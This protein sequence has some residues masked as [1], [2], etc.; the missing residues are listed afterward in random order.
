[1]LAASPGQSNSE[2]AFE[3]KKFGTFTYWL[4]DALVATS[5]LADINQGEIFKQVEK[6]TKKE[7]SQQSPFFQGDRHKKLFSTEL[8]YCP[9]LFELTENHWKISS[10]DLVELYS[11]SLTQPSHSFPDMYYQFGL[12]FAEKGNFTQAVDALNIYLEQI[13]EQQNSKNILFALGVAQFKSQLYANAIETFEKYLGLAD[14]NLDLHSSM[15]QVLSKAQSLIEPFHVLLVGVDEYL[16]ESNQN[17]ESG[18]D[19]ALND[20][21]S[22]KS[23]LIER[24]HFKE[25]ILIERG[26]LK[27][28]FFYITSLLNDE[29]TTETILEEFKKL[30]EYS[31]GPTFFYFSGR[32]AVDAEG[33]PAI[34][35]TDSRQ[36]G[37]PDIR[38]DQLAKIAS[39]TDS[40][41]IS[42]IDACWTDSKIRN[43]RYTSSEGQASEKVQIVG[44]IERSSIRIPRVGH[45]TLYPES[46]KYQQK[47][48][49]KQSFTSEL[50]QILKNTEVNSLSYWNLRQTFA[51]NQTST[52]FDDYSG[53][54]YISSDDNALDEAV[55]SNPLRSKLQLTLQ[56]IE[57]APLKQTVDIIKEFIGQQ[58]GLSPSD[59]LN[60]GLMNYILGEYNDSISALQ[61]AINQLSEQSSKTVKQQPSSIYAQVHYWLGRV[62]HERRIDP[63]RAVSELRLAIQHDP[64]NV[65]AHYYLGQTLRVLGGPEIL[66]EAKRALQ[67][68][69]KKGAPLGQEEEIQAF[70]QL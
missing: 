8:N 5:N 15:S 22:L 56:Q 27:E 18:N 9:A 19:Q 64:S 52:D 6:A 34:L 44:N 51:R 41:L 61:T 43:T 50:I 63:A 29:A 4:V 47:E 66:M 53:N 11:R 35:A 65:F 12:A 62:L 17:A 30:V 24:F 10:D 26:H 39:N 55:F 57:Q 54:I 42:I 58:N 69:L 32:G 60:L 48:R 13:Q 20:V 3:G 7:S 25:S 40:N 23:V 38:V 28:E 21:I 33:N 2:V 31:P 14:L 1:M 49:V 45:I 70:L 46:I 59:Y 67:A 37:V 16:Y 68:Y 36:D